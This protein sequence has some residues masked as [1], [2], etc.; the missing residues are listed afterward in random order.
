MLGVP[1]ADRPQFKSWS[2]DLVYFLGNAPN[3]EKCQQLLESLTHFMDYFRTILHQH[4]LSP[5]DDLIDVLVHAEDRGVTL[6]EEELLVN[7]VGFF[8]GGHETTTNLIGN[9]MLA[10]LR[11]PQEL[12]RLQ[13]HPDLYPSAIEELLRYDSPVQFTARIARETTEIG[14]KKIY[15][16]MSV[17]FM[18]GAANRDPARF[19]EPDTLHLSRQD[20]RHLAFGSN[21]HYCIG[22]AL[23]RLEGQIAI[24]TLLRRMPDIRLAGFP[25]QWQENLS[26]HGLTALP[27]TF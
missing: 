25:L 21:I 9:G 15:K 8:A 13:E 20:N 11:N 7:C 5:Q 2:D 14:G 12:C 19:Q 4:R 18:L 23:A 10:L 22:A 24:E 1:V 6:T 3:L 27:V 26:F 17:M 16:G